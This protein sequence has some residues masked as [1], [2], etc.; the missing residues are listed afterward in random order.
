VLVVEPDALTAGFIVGRLLDAGYQVSAVSTG[1]DA[2]DRC[3]VEDPSVVIAEL[4]LADLDG[5]E[6]CRGVRALCS[7]AFVVVTADT[8]E[9]RKV[10]ALDAGADDYITKPFSAPE[11]LARIRV[12]IRHRDAVV[13]PDPYVR[14]QVGSLII[15]TADRVATMAGQP[16]KLTPKEFEFLELLARQPGTLVSQKAILGRVWG[17][18][19][20]RRSEYLRVYANQLRKK[21]GADPSGPHLVTEP[22]LGYRLVAQG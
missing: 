7:A 13:A 11:L 4:C 5:I 3:A 22:R 18:Q 21:L 16:L 10:D 8:A 15:D 14:I 20:I 9:Q 1:R 17:P 2:L 19:A 6:V 12:A